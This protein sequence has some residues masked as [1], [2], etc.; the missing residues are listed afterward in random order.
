MNGN[1]ILLIAIRIL[2]VIVLIKG[3]GSLISVPISYEAATQYAASPLYLTSLSAVYSI[4]YISIGSLL[5]FSDK[6]IERIIDQTE[7]ADAKITKVTMEQ[8]IQVLGLYFIVTAASGFIEY[9]EWIFEA[10]SSVTILANLWYP[11]L[12]E[13]VIGIILMLKP[14]VVS[15]TLSKFTKTPNTIK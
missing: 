13:V 14:L 10:K 15:S 11:H 8:L 4:V 7:R 9:S 2:G 6:L 3:I 5:L 1:D 12:V